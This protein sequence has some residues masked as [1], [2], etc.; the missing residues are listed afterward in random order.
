M[1]LVVAELGDFGHLVVGGR[2]LRLGRGLGLLTTL[3]LL[4]ELLSL[5]L[6]GVAHD[7]PPKAYNGH[8]AGKL[9]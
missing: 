2:R 4:D 6:L 9:T 1:R 5:L 3:L 8:V 7:E